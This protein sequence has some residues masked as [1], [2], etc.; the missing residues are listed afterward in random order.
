[1]YIMQG[2][3]RYPQFPYHSSLHFVINDRLFESDYMQ[4]SM[5]GA[6]VQEWTIANVHVALHPFHLHSHHVQV[7]SVTPPLELMEPFIGTWNDVV[8]CIRQLRFCSLMLQL[9]MTSH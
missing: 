1:M 4:Y 5:T 3:I 9:R 7:V 2:G 6:A 8:S